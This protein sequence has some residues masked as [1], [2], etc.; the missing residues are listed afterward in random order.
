MCIVE[1]HVVHSGVHV[2]YTHLQVKGSYK[3]T[4]Y[5]RCWAAMLT[6]QS[7]EPGCCLLQCITAVRAHSCCALE[8]MA[9]EEMQR[10]LQYTAGQPTTVTWSVCSTS[11][12]A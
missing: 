1:G 3:A 11:F 4:R 7:A 5:W 6:T 10:G 9:A 2:P 8:V 12:W